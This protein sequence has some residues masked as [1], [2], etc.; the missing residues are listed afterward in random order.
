MPIFRIVG[1]SLILSLFALHSTKVLAISWI[2]PAGG[3][4]DNGANWSTGVPPSS[5]D[6]VLFDLGGV[7]DVSFDQHKSA[8]GVAVR[9]E[10]AFDLG[11]FIYSMSSLSVS[12]TLVPGSLTLR[13]GFGSVLGGTTVGALT[14]AAE[15]IVDGFGAGLALGGLQIASSGGEGRVVVRDG[16]RLSSEDALLGWMGADSLGTVIVDGLGSNWTSSGVIRLGSTEGS[17]GVLEIVN[18]G[19]VVSPAV[20][21]GRANQSMGDVLVSGPLSQLIVQEGLVIGERADATF[22]LDDRG[23]LEASKV[24]IGEELS[25]A[26]ALTVSGGRDHP[27]EVAFDVGE[28]IVGSSGDGAFEATEG[29]QIESGNVTIGAAPGGFGTVSVSGYDPVSWNNTTWNMQDGSTLVIGDFGVGLMEIRDGAWLWGPTARLTLG[30]HVG[31]IGQLSVINDPMG[32]FPTDVFVDDLV[33]A[34]LGGG[35]ATLR[36]EGYANVNALSVAIGPGGEIIGDGWVGGEV[37]ECFGVL[38]PGLPIG[39][40]SISSS[41]STQSTCTVEI[42]IGGR[43]P[44]EE[45]DVLDGSFDGGLVVRLVNGFEPEAGDSFSV[46]PQAVFRRADMPEL[47]PGLSW[48][49]PTMMGGNLQVSFLCDDGMDNDGDGLIDFP[50]DPGCIDTASIMEDPSCQDGDDN[51]GDGLIDFDGGASAGLP[52][53]QQTAPDPQCSHP[54]QMQETPAGSCGLGIELALLLPPLMWLSRRRRS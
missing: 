10:V 3:S 39:R 26:G 38:R 51:D 1:V 33:V 25:A 20:S 40:L 36:L 17:A 50:N 54:W 47:S 21:V 28:L 32:F 45:F 52:H 4:Y 34:P 8:E 30:E 22:V 18:G 43:T 31:A 23:V 41:A 19:L 35:F 24:T 53:E 44:E 5:S 46:A 7:Y 49:D 13:N 16:G 2:N 42:E 27:E 6:P 37:S 9:D 48:R 11:D 29:V 15:L 12:E 14:G